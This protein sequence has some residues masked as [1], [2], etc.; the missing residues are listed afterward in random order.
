M[1]T[2]HPACDSIAHALERIDGAIR[3]DTVKN[4]TGKSW[5]FKPLNSV[6]FMRRKFGIKIIF[7]VTEGIVAMNIVTQED[8]SYCLFGKKG[9]ASQVI[10]EQLAYTTTI[11]GGK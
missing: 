9:K 8:I 5:F 11:N 6:N 3:R 7:K 10:N 2:K 1:R 4:S